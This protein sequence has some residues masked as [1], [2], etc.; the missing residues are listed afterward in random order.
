MTKR[1]FK[2]TKTFTASLAL[3]TA[4]SAAPAFADGP[5]VSEVPKTKKSEAAVLSSD[6]L[7]RLTEN[8]TVKGGGG[9]KVDV[10]DISLTHYTDQAAGAGVVEDWKWDA[11][12]TAAAGSGGEDRLTE[13]LTVKGGDDDDIGFQGGDVESEGDIALNTVSAGGGGGK[14]AV[15][16]IS[17]TTYADQPAPSGETGEPL[18]SKTEAGPLAL[19]LGAIIAV[20]AVDSP[21]CV[22]EGGAVDADCNGLDDAAQD[23]ARLD[24]LSKTTR[25]AKVKSR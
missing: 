9:G 12:Q 24:G 5:D 8:V 23:P 25:R 19:G 3:M 2:S 15:Q 11:K 6:G 21:A 1:F 10:Q 14:V 7:D 4:M 16:D 20:G 22:T 13:N 17:L 18:P